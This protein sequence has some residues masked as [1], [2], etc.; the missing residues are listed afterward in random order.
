MRRL[1]LREHLLADPRPED[2]T[3]LVETREDDAVGRALLGPHGH[4]DADDRSVAR[5]T[6][7]LAHDACDVVRVLERVRRVDDVER[8]VGEGHL[9]HVHDEDVLPL[10]EHVDADDVLEPVRAEPVE[11][12]RVATADAQNGAAGRLRLGDRVDQRH[13]AGTGS[14]SLFDSVRRSC[15]DEVVRGTPADCSLPSRRR[16]SQCGA[17]R[18]P[19]RAGSQA[20]PDTRAME[21]HG[22]DRTRRGPD[23]CPHL[24]SRR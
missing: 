24:A 5:H 11:L 14:V 17:S 3:Q 7:D 21:A 8:V 18:Q 15:V 16:L 1:L 20:R 2:V 23:R 19:P 6:R 10:R 22:A 13:G 12:E 4:L 9:V